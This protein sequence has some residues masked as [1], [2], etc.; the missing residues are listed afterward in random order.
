MPRDQGLRGRVFLPGDHLARERGPAV[1]PEQRGRG[2]VG[3]GVLL[4]HVLAEHKSVRAGDAVHHAVPRSAL[5]VRRH[6][7][8]LG[9]HRRRHRGRPTTTVS[10]RVRGRRRQKRRRRRFRG[11]RRSVDRRAGRRAPLV[12]PFAAHRTAAGRGHRG[13]EGPSPASARRVQPAR[14]PVRRARRI[15][16]GHVVRDG[17]VRHLLLHDRPDKDRQDDSVHLHV[18]APVRYEVLHDRRIG[19]RHDQTGEPITAANLMAS[20]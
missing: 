11:T 5:H 15:V 3:V 18:A 19:S 16:A 6:Q 9:T 8:R 4:R 2:H 7:P 17:V 1:F 14:R 10:G 20:S 12:V 13:T